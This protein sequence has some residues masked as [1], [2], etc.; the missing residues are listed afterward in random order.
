MLLGGLT[1]VGMLE[2]FVFIFP[3]NTLSSSA[4]ESVVTGGNFF[5]WV[6]LSS[7]S[8]PFTFKKQFFFS[9]PNKRITENRKF[10]SENKTFARA[11]RE[12]KIFLGKKHHQQ[13]FHD[14]GLKVSS[15]VGFWVDVNWLDLRAER[16]EAP[17][18][19]LQKRKWWIYDKR[20]RLKIIRQSLLSFFVHVV[21][22]CRNNKTIFSCLMR[23]FVGCWKTYFY[24]KIIAFRDLESTEENGAES[25]AKRKK[26]CSFKFFSNAA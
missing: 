1:G 23:F 17:E 8:L 19:Y 15:G 14:G 7:S 26:F 22:R 12:T 2:L 3:N 18:H 13:V 16:W 11:A 9:P 6:S 4:L 10:K 25:K 20:G 21:I 24:A 5:I